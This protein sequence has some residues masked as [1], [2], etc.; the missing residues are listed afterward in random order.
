MQSGP[1]GGNPLASGQPVVFSVQVG[2]QGSSSSV[3]SY[4][5]GGFVLYDMAVNNRT[6][7]S[8]N[9]GPK[10]RWQ[11]KFIYQ[12]YTLGTGRCVGAELR[13]PS[14]DPCTTRSCVPSEDR[15]RSVGF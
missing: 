11:M 14:R 1:G 5:H 3:Y 8:R 2:A 4:A 13:R 7:A 9:A 6:A 12:Q 15:R 10:P